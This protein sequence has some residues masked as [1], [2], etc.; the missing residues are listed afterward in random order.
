MT[1]KSKN[2]LAVTVGFKSTLVSLVFV[3]LKRI[4]E[5]AAQTASMNFYFNPFFHQRKIQN[6]KKIIKVF[7]LR[8]MPH[9]KKK[10][11]IE[12]YNKGKL[13]KTKTFNYNLSLLPFGPAFA[14][15]LFLTIWLFFPLNIQNSMNILQVFRLNGVS[16]KHKRRQ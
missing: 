9:E 11:I 12:S 8:I 1:K 14:S 4:I 2:T 15:P 7:Y 16:L 6:K 13:P 3:Q 10:K 5:Q